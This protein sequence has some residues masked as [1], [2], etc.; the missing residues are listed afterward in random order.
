ML[1]PDCQSGAQHNIRKIQ[2]GAWKL[3]LLPTG[4]FQTH[5]LSRSTIILQCPGWV[6]ARHLGEV[7][8]GDLGWRRENSKWRRAADTLAPRLLCPGFSADSSVTDWPMLSRNSEAVKLESEKL[9]DKKNEQ[10]QPGH[11]S[12]TWFKSGFTAAHYCVTTRASY[13][14][15]H[16]LIWKHWMILV[17]S[18][19]I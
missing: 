6:R 5:I 8:T 15:P 9:A 19:D 18:G 4:Y 11:V 7:G 13:P 2:S 3:L 17:E 1:L 14:E 10:K 12:Q 16:F